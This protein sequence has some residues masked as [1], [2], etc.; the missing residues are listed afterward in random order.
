MCDFIRFEGMVYTLDV[1]A[2]IFS[3]VVLVQLPKRGRDSR[4]L[5][6]LCLPCSG[7]PYTFLVAKIVVYRAT[8]RLK[9]FQGTPRVNK[10]MIRT[11]KKNTTGVTWPLTSY[12]DRT[13]MVPFWITSKFCWFLLNWFILSISVDTSKGITRLGRE[14]IG[15][16]L[17]RQINIYK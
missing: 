14:R 1:M 17:G 5:P 12:Q 4:R 3:F 6:S 13:I 11:N 10:H 9:Y 8:K 16:W 15:S 7:R 2:P